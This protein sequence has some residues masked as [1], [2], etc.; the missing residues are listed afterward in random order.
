MAASYSRPGC[1][2]CAESQPGL[3]CGVCTDLHQNANAAPRTRREKIR[4]AFTR[5]LGGATRTPSG[6]RRGTAICEDDHLW[7][8][9]TLPGRNDEVEEPLCPQCGKYLLRIGFVQGEYAEDVEC[10]DICKN[11]QD[12]KCR[13]SCGGANHGMNLGKLKFVQR[14]KRR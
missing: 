5:R 1:L 9:V 13:C 11:A 12:F 3:A 6:V 8:T 7:S 4:K 2:V 14:K 10:V